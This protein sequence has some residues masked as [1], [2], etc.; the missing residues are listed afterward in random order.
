MHPNPNSRSSGR[1]LSTA[2][3][4]YDA[5]AWTYSARVHDSPVGANNP[6]PTRSTASADPN[7]R[8]PLLPQNNSAS[9]TSQTTWAWSVLI[10]KLLT[11][12]FLTLCVR[13]AWGWMTKDPLDPAVRDRLRRQWDE[14]IQGHEKIRQAWAIEVEQHDTIRIGWEAERMEL[15]AMRE[16]LVRDKEDWKDE[17]R[18][19]ARRKKEE[20][21]RIRATFYWEDLRADQHCLRYST[22]Q[23]TARVANVPRQYDPVQ[24]CKETAI[25]INGLKIHSPVQCEDRGCGGVIGHWMA[26]DPSCVTYF[27]GFADKGCTGPGSGRR[28]IESRLWNLQ[29]GD[30]WRDMCS[31]TP[32]RF[33]G[34]HFGGPDSCENWGFRGVWGT[35][36]IEDR[37]CS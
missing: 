29:D 8:M 17:K 12:I 25:E 34:L 5:N 14:E 1:V 20:Q 26:G 23:Y 2:P 16:Q 31:T 11:L 36:N 35:W 32:A 19:E 3:P 18:G 27:D 28:A 10:Y 7:D 22:R 33:R 37:E 15:I 9:S 30:N 24:A 4:A 13:A 21:D 6:R